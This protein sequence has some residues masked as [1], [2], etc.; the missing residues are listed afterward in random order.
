[1][2]SKHKATI[3]A[4]FINRDFAYTPWEHQ[5]MD[6]LNAGATTS[7]VIM[8]ALKSGSFGAFDFGKEQSVTTIKT[9]GTAGGKPMLRMSFRGGP[10]TLLEQM[11]T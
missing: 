6:V 9:H 3:N 5:N 8:P 11:L 1:M 2:H 10:C 4:S 7:K